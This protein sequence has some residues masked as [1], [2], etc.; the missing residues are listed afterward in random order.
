VSKNIEKCGNRRSGKRL[1]RRKNK[2][3]QFFIKF[4]KYEFWLIINLNILFEIEQEVKKLNLK[5][6]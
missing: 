5:Y 1:T 6:F 2:G 3:L 4:C